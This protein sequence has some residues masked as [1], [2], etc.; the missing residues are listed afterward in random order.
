MSLAAAR[1]A[2]A[3]RAACTAEVS[4]S[5]QNAAEEGKDNHV[6]LR[7]GGLPAVAGEPV[8]TCFSPQMVASI[9]PGEVRTPAWSGIPGA[10]MRSLRWNLIIVQL[11]VSTGLQI[12]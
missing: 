10:R 7:M 4:W 12:S 11:F 6:G 9:P 5:L 2:L 8:R 3:K 1:C